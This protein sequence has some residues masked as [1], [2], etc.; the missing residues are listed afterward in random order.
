[1]LVQHGGQK[2]ELGQDGGVTLNLRHAFHA[3]LRQRYQSLNSRDTVF[4]SSLCDL[5]GVAPVL[6]LWTVALSD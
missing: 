1:M 4:A 5:A 3:T 2:T 6:A